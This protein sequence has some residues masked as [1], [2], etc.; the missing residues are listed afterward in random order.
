[1]RR[2]ELKPMSHS[3]YRPTIHFS[4][5]DYLFTYAWLVHEL[6]DTDYLFLVGRSGLCWRNV[7]F[8]PA[9]HDNPTTSHCVY[10]LLHLDSLFEYPLWNGMGV[11]PVTTHQL[12]VVQQQHIRILSRHVNVNRK[13][14]R[15]RGNGNFTQQ[16]LT[17]G[18]RNSHPQTFGLWA[19]LKGKNAVGSHGTLS[20]LALFGTHLFSATRLLV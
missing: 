16:C 1:M 4:S 15:H 14:C 9:F 2:P 7:H 5:A 11:Y 19:L 3:K 8:D 6:F 17:A 20:L 12:K 10:S 18:K 13:C